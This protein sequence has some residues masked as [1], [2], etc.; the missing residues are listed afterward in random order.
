MKAIYI[1][2]REEF[3]LT[4]SCYIRH[5]D[6]SLWLAVSYITEDGVTHT[7]E[8]PTESELPVHPDYQLIL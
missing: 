5:E 1:P 2:T 4:G 6:D 3:I 8:F 7:N